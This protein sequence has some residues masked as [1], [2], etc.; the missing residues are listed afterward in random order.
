MPLSRGIARFNRVVTN[1]ISR[2]LASRLPGFALI[3][4]K[5]RVSGNEYRTPINCWIDDESAVV[6]LTYGADTDWLKNLMAAG[7]GRVLAQGDIYRVG[8]PRLVGPEGMS[9][10]PAVVRPIL[11]L[12]DVDAFAELP[13]LSPGRPT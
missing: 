6:A 5:G 11:N 2:P 3:L 12:I 10:M 9:R 13:L 4:H 1:R 7:G 8:M